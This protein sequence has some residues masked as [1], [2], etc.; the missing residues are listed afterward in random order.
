MEL[1]A[2]PD[3]GAPAEV[4]THEAYD[5][6]PGDTVRVQ[7]VERHWFLGPRRL[8]VPAGPRQPGVHGTGRRGRQPEPGR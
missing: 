5:E 6:H 3:C 2:C 8:L 1:C 4:S 7:C